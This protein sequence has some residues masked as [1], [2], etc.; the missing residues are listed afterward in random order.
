MSAILEVPVLIAGGGPVGTTLALDLAYRGIRSLVVEERLAMPP[1]PK[2]NTTN[3]R[4][5]EHFRRLGCA[6]AIRRV[7]LPLDHPTD[8]VY[9][10]RW[11]GKELTR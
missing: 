3:A 1:N 6:D 9:A 4:S 10:T 2:C 7:G 8:V 5:M 11:L